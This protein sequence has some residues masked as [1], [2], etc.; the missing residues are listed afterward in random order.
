MTCKEA[1]RVLSY[2]ATVANKSR[3]DAPPNPFILYKHLASSNWIQ[4][5]GAPFGIAGER[6]WVSLDS[7]TLPFLEGLI[8]S[9]KH[10][11]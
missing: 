8:M 1:L 9:V 7:I 3:Y 11:L 4:I 6:I 10:F 2:D 5:V